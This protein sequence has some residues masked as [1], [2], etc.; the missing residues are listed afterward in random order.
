ML[1]YVQESILSGFFTFS[2]AVG[3]LS[4]CLLLLIVCVCVCV[5]V[6]ACAQVCKCL[7]VCV[8]IC[9]C[10]PACMYVCAYMCMCVLLFFFCYLEVF[11]SFFF[12]EGLEGVEIISREIWNLEGARQ[13]GRQG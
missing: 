13:A 9:A 7:F 10:A 1:K 8:C 11:P 4:L 12:F 5:C 3:I 6:C 2:L